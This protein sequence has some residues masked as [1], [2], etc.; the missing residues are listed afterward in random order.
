MAQDVIYDFLAKHPKEW[1]CVRDIAQRT[2][3]PQ[4]NVSEG[5]KRMRKRKV[6][7]HK[8]DRVPMKVID[9]SLRMKKM[10]IYKFKKC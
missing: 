2:G 5:M 3:Q 1:F 4:N 6:V 8:R 9:G 7:Y 10:N